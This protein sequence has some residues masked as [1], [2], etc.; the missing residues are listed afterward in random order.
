MTAVS[1]ETRYLRGYARQIDGTRDRVLA[2]MGDYCSSHCGR[3]DG[4]NGL[5][6]P[7]RSLVKVQE[8]SHAKLI[9]AARRSLWLTAYDLRNAAD[10]YDRSDSASAERLWTSG[11]AW[12]MPDGH[13]ER[14]VAVDCPEFSQGASV[15]LAAPERRTD[16]DAAQQAVTDM[17]GDVNTLIKWVTGYDLLGS[18]MPIVLG[19]TGTLRSVAQAYGE[20][21][22]GFVAISGD[23][24]RGMDILSERWDSTGGGASAAFDYHIRKRWIPAVDALATM[25]NATEENF[26]CLAEVYEY[27]VNALLIALNFYRL[28]LKKALQA[29]EAATSVKEALWRLFQLVSDLYQLINDLVDI[30]VKQTA[31]FIE[32]A[33][34]IAAVSRQLVDVMQDDFEVLRTA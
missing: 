4:L 19:E 13:R 23:L 33:E 24:D 22:R 20:L 5:L 18:T 10:S 26:E 2:A 16:I 30:L 12:A 25:A 7:T 15:I 3:T 17:L 8:E 34:Q 32:E 9:D 14:D 28:R 29:L 21:E 31:M 11:R 27:V 6:S 1:V